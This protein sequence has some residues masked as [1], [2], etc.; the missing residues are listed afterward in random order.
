M[1]TLDSERTRGNVEQAIY[2]Q[3]DIEMYSTTE[4]SKNAGYR[5]SYEGGAS[6]QTEITAQSSLG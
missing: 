2:V 6:Q 1:T 4:L 5:P 3:K